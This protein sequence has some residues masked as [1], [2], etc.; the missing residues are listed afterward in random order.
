MEGNMPY[1]VLIIMCGY[2]GFCTTAVA[3]VLA[4]S[5]ALRAVGENVTAEP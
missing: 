2:A 3:G 1:F 5:S 4:F